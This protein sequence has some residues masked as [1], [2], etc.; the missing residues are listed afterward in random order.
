MEKG[1]AV[2]HTTTIGFLLVGLS[3]QK[4]FFRRPG[5]RIRDDIEVMNPDQ[6]RVGYWCPACRGMFVSSVPTAPEY[7]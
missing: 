2:I 5:A 4:L 3:W 1:A 7:Q 6:R